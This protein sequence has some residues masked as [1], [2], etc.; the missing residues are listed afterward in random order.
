MSIATVRR[1][2]RPIVPGIRADLRDH[3]RLIYRTAYGVTGSVEDAQD[4]LQTIFLR[5]LR[6][7]LPPLF[8]QNS[9]SKRYSWRGPALADAV[10]KQ[11]GLRM[12]PQLVPVEVLLIDSEERPSPN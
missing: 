8:I 7:D 1:E 12:Q 10:E 5:L 2:R 11:L 6:R 3:S 9:A 4:I